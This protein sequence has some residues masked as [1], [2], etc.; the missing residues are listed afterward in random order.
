MSMDKEA[1]RDRSAEDAAGSGRGPSAGLAIGLIAALLF[2]VFAGMGLLPWMSETIASARSG[3]GGV[4]GAL[5]DTEN[6]KDADGRFVILEYP[7]DAA[8]GYVDIG[9]LADLRIDPVDMPEITDAD[10]EANMESWIIYY[11]YEEVRTEGIVSKG[12]RAVIAYSCYGADGNLIEGYSSEGAAMDLGYGL[13]PEGWSDALDGAAIGEM[14]TFPASFP[15][16]WPDEDA[17]GMAVTFEATVLEVRSIPELTDD[18]IADKLGG[19]FDTVDA[20][21]DFV[22]S[23]LEELDGNAYREAVY[24]AA[25]E[26]LTA[27]S[28]FKPI[29]TALLEW[30]VSVQMKYYQAAADDRGITV[31]DYL[32]SVGL[33][34]NPDKVANAIAETAGDAVRRYALLTA[35]ADQAGISVDPEGEDRLAVGYRE[36]DLIAGLGLRDNDDLFAFYTEANVLNDVR[37]TKTVDWLIANVRQEPLPD[38]GGAGDGGTA[39]EGS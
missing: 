24:A 2:G 38:A 26:A 1:K 18:N 28:T 8:A 9:D 15:E 36:V 30:Y 17:A 23:S 32:E 39:S 25:I 33:G 22:R 19:E 7:A 11:G 31:G 10:V 34:D 16:S 37:N 6:M 29:P 20:F 14:I 27:Q 3:S 12:E 5:V 21:R 13:E 4:M 35:V